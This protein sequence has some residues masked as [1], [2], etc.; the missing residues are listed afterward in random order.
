M[1]AG[2]IMIAVLALVVE[3]V[4]EVVQRMAVSPG[5]RDV[6]TRRRTARIWR[7]PTPDLVK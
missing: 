2:A 6:A 1:A 4:L 7:R 5:L 3:G